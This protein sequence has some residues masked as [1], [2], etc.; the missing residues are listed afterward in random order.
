MDS[1]RCFHR[2]RCLDAGEKCKDCRHNMVLLEAYLKE[3]GHYFEVLPNTKE[4]VEYCPR[5]IK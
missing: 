1:T 4:Y 5:Y 3:A 2:D